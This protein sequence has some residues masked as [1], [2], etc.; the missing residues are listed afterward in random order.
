MFK[1]QNMNFVKKLLSFCIFL[2]CPMVSTK[3]YVNHNQPNLTELRKFIEVNNNKSGYNE[4]IVKNNLKFVV[5]MCPVMVTGGPENLSQLY[6]ELKKLGLETYFY[7]MSDVFAI[8]K[9]YQDGTWYLCKDEK[10]TMNSAYVETY[11]VNSLERDIPL[12]DKTLVI[13]S[14]PLADMI[15]LFENARTAIAWLSIGNFRG[16][17]TELL[18]YFIF[19]GK[20]RDV[21]CIHFSQS[22]WIQKKLQSWGVESFLLGDYINKAY[23]SESAAEKINNSVAFFPRKAKR[24]GEAFVAQYNNFNY[25][26]LQ[27]LD[28]SGMIKAL[29]SAKIYIDFGDFPGR[30]RVPREAL[31]R[32]CVIFIRN[33]ACATDFDSFPIDD[34]FRFSDKDVVDG[35]LY[36]KVCETLANYENMKKMQDFMRQQVLEEPALFEKNVKDFFGE[37]LGL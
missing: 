23:L 8:K 19:N 22:P 11:G 35:T 9:R 25:I 6:A 14:E 13:V 32:N 20:L 17:D 34:Y 29:D 16:K 5:I 18:Q 27:N 26:R 7:W 28:K 1:R 31:L 33:V 37:P 15:A 24:L 30:D 4:K 12:D 10:N 21:Q 36:K 3:R 2:Y